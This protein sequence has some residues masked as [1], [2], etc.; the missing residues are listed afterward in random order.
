MADSVVKGN[1]FKTVLNAL[2][3][4]VPKSKNGKIAAGSVLGGTAV[5]SFVL[6]RLS[7]KGKK[8]SK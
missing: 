1:P 5:A 2:K 4:A 7:K 8:A 6:G 3:D